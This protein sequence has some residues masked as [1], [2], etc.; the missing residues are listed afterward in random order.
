MRSMSLEE[1]ERRLEGH[2]YGGQIM[3]ALKGAILRFRPLAVVLLGE[4]TREGAGSMA[5]AEF[6]FIQDKGM[7]PSNVK[8]MMRR[9]DEFGVLDLFF[10]EVTQ[11]LKL[12][13]EKDPLGREVMEEGVVV[14][15]R[16]DGVWR[17]IEEM[18][19]L[20][21]HLDSLKEKRGVH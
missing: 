19:S 16:D 4:L 21:G 6:L 10:L 3:L 17:Y 15:A 8:K 5:E 18:A 7:C 20:A 9:L 11:F 2:I 14:Y 1:L 13:K 12:V